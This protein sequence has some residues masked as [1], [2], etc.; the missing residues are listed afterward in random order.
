[1]HSVLQLRG[2]GKDDSDS[3]M[4]TRDSDSSENGQSAIMSLS[5]VAHA[6]I[7]GF[8]KGPKH[9]T[10]IYAINARR[11]KTV[12]RINELLYEF[13]TVDCDVLL[14]RKAWRP[15]GEDILELVCV[16]S[17]PFWHFANRQ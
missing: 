8:G 4:A 16:F 14:V 3:C 10:Q 1:M 6:K 13:K 5:E 12:E 11:L 15:E 17:M 2:E 9:T 7:E